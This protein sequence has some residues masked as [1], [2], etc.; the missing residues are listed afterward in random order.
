MKITPIRLDD[1]LLNELEIYKKIFSTKNRSDT[2]RTILVKYMS[3]EKINQ[4]MNHLKYLNSINIA[5]EN[6]INNH[7]DEKIITQLDQIVVLLNYVYLN[8]KEEKE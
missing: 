1:E 6:L 5:I 7:D 2:I 8:Q 3:E 4:D